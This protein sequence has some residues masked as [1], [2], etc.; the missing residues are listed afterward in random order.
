MKLS[1]SSGA[2]YRFPSEL[3]SLEF[4][5][6]LLLLLFKGEG[7]LL[8]LLGLAEAIEIFDDFRGDIDPCPA[9]K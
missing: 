1:G 3:P 5:E 4:M 9:L 6:K 7:L 2:A 8:I